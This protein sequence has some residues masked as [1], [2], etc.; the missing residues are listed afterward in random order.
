MSDEQN[1][2]ELLRQAQAGDRR[3]M[4]LLLGWLR[5]RVKPMAQRQL[6]GRPLAR[7]DASDVAQE[8]CF[9]LH[10]NWERLH[11]NCPLPLL[12]GWAR[13]VLQ[14]VVADGCRRGKREM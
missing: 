13:K 2:D 5:Q 7:M 11:D 3:S 6:Q 10:R 4:N 9:R 12:L 14:N 1:I 8:V